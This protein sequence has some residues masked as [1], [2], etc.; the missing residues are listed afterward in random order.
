MKKCQIFGLNA[1]LT[2]NE[3]WSNKML[4]KGASRTVT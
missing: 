2:S 1:S 4:H 3:V